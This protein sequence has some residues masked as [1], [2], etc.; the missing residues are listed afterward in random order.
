MKG[1]KVLNDLF[2]ERK[3]PESAYAREVAEE[4]IERSERL[5]SGV[6]TKWFNKKGVV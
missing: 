4:R 5:S 6:A 3:S 1:G 2:S